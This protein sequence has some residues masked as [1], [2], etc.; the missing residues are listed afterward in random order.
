MQK[1][2]GSSPIIRSRRLPRS[3]PEN[4]EG[5]S[6][7]LGRLR[8]IFVGAQRPSSEKDAGAASRTRARPRPR[9]RLVSASTPCLACRI[10]D[11]FVYSRD[12]AGAGA[13][14]DDDELR[15]EHW[16]YMDR[17]AESMIA[18]GPTLGPDPDTATGSLHVLGLPSVAAAKEFVACEPNN[19]AGVYG[20]H[21]IWRFDNLLGRTMWE[22]SGD[23]E[24]PMFLVVARSHRRQ[25]SET[26]HNSVPAES[27][28]AELRMRLI[29]YG[30]LTTLDDAEPAGVALAVQ[31]ADRKALDE[32][33][34]NER[35]GLDGGPGLEIHNWEFGGR[36]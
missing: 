27:L 14:R 1:V 19:R 35:L 21:S 36:R 31:A 17:F 23:A 10:V 25:T 26:S 16:S 7:P 2:V 13:L 5:F 30:A 3:V 15:E 8:A 12:A 24:E 22:F 4:V 11:F 32:F 18:R 34:G 9:R 6:P 20:E 28:P 33:L 29:L